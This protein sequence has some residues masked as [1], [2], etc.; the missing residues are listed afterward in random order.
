MD[1]LP[2]PP[3]GRRALLVGFAG[4][5]GRENAEIVARYATVVGG[6]DIDPGAQELAERM[7]MPFFPTVADAVVGVDFDVAVVTV[8]HHAHFEVCIEVLNAGKHIIKEKPFAVSETD[9]RKIAELARERGLAVFTLVQ[10]RFNPSFD[11]AE[12]NLYRIGTPYWFRYDYHM[13]LSRP[14]SGWR[15]DPR[16]AAGGVVLDMGYHLADV[17]VRFFPEPSCV[18][19]TFHYAHEQMRERGLEDLATISF[20]FDVEN[21]SGTMTVSR[22]SHQK[23]EE[24]VV[25]GTAGILSATPKET[26]IHSLG[27]DALGSAEIS[28]SKNIMIDQMWHYYLRHLDDPEARDQH[29]TD[30]LAAVRLVDSIYDVA[31]M[32]PASPVAS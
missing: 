24:L 30:Q 32:T 3:R 17:L 28:R 10:R 15:A 21:F 2:V 31:P 14:T 7:A 23:S 20:G 27:G 19:S 12:Q 13:S 1:V 16:H 22:H 25:L 6:V 8:P 29:L 26:T 4:Q 5:Q 18:R 11:F 9:A